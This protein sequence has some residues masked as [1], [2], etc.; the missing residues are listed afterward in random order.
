[1]LRLREQKPLMEELVMWGNKMS[2][3]TNLSM[4]RSVE[5]DTEEEKS[6]EREIGPKDT[7][8][9]LLLGMVRL[10]VLLI[11]IEEV[12]LWLRELRVL[13]I[14]LGGLVS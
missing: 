12:L 3:R 10:W 2:M 9:P 11:E 4:D 6:E 14:R 13:K 7:Q 8:I 1:M 5:E